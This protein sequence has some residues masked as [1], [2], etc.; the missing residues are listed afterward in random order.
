M[1]AMQPTI[2]LL[3]ALLAAVAVGCGVS[4]HQIETY[5]GCRSRCDSELEHCTRGCY[6]PA[7]MWSNTKTLRC[8]DE[9][10]QKKAECGQ[11]CSRLEGPSP[12]PISEN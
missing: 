10:N 1:R 3:M 5:E 9:C 6:S 12:E 11:L 2:M 7:R 8:V 4:K